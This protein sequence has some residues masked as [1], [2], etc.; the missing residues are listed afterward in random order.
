MS[1][2]QPPSAPGNKTTVSVEDKPD[3]PQNGLSHIIPDQVTGI[4]VNS[5]I[6]G[7]LTSIG[8]KNQ[9]GANGADLKTKKTSP[10]Q[11][12]TDNKNAT[13]SLDKEPIK[14]NVED[15]PSPEDK[16]SPEDKKPEQP[17]AE[18]KTI[19]SEPKSP[20]LNGYLELHAQ[21]KKD[22][23]YY[24]KMVLAQQLKDV[25]PT[26][27]EKIEKVFDDAKDYIA[28]KGNLP[29]SG[30]NVSPNGNIVAKGKGSGKSKPENKIVEETNENPQI[31]NP[32]QPKNG[33]IKQANLDKPQ[34]DV[35]SEQTPETKKKLPAAENMNF[36]GGKVQPDMGKKKKGQSEKKGPAGQFDISG[37][38]N[39]EQPKPNSGI[40]GMTQGLEGQSGGAI[41]E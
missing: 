37:I 24:Q 20:D 16:T 32:D 25:L 13:T 27:K 2:I 1:D 28:A 31:K 3:S 22:D 18:T 8:I 23:P 26:S 33:G 39:A 38:G 35:N 6:S 9:P 41:D 12:P 11:P 14:T 36:K 30:E 4:S 5:P 29:I 21:L 7:Q 15:K 17:A 19:H 40:G 34:K 10:E